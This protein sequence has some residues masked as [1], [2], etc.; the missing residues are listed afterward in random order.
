MLRDLGA[1]GGFGV[2]DDGRSLLSRSLLWRRGKE[3]TTLERIPP[4]VQGAVQLP[5]WSWM[6]YDGAID[7]VDLPLGGVDWQEDE[8]HGPWSTSDAE[9]QMEEAAGRGLSAIVRPFRWEP[10]N[11]DHEDFEIDLDAGE[12]VGTEGWA[13]WQCVVVGTKKVPKGR[14]IQIA[15]RTHYLLIIAPTTNGDGMYADSGFY[16]RIGVGKAPGALIGDAMASRVVI[17]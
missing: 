7:F 15:E 11:V 8:I 17:H 12:D 16:T 4:E 1:R 13:D 2:F 14:V 10:T 6:A 9:E 5:S 3:V